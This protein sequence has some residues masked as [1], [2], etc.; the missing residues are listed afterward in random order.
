MAFHKSLRDKEYEKAELTS[1][2]TRAKTASPR[3]GF[4]RPQPN[5]IL[6]L[7]IGHR[8]CVC[9][10]TSVFALGYRG[11]ADSHRVERNL[12]C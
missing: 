5:P 2:L 7:S 6:S 4:C 10:Q 11:L 9:V 12:T 3:R 8:A 1:N